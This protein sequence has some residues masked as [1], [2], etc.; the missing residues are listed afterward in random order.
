MSLYS[1]FKLSEEKLQQ[2]TK[3]VF[4]PNDDGT[5]PTFILGYMSNSNQR[6]TK[7]LER[8]SKPH[9]RLIELKRLPAE[10]DAAI[11]RRVFCQTILL[12][13]ENVQDVNGKPFVYTLENAIKLLTDLPELFTQLKIEASN[14]SRFLE[15]ELEDEAKN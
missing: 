4:S 9:Q 14:R 6:Y 2:G 12:G 15:A 8:E 13:W 1:E 5:V 11:M 7:C 10:T 3:V